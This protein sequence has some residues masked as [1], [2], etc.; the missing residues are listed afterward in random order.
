MSSSRWRKSPSHGKCSRKYCGSSLNYG[1]SHHQRQRETFDGHAFKSTT[2]GVR[3]NARE[4]GQISPRPP[5]GLPDAPVAVRTSRLSCGKAGKARIFTPVWDSSGESR[6][7]SLSEI[8]HGAVAIALLTLR[9][10]AVARG[11]RVFGVIV[12]GL[13]VI[14]DCAVEII[15][16]KLDQSS[17]S[18]ATSVRWRD[19]NHFSVVRFGTIEL[20]LRAINIAT[21]DERQQ[22]IR[23]KLDLGREVGSGA[24][25]ITLSEITIATVAQGSCILWIE[26]DC[27]GEVRNR[28]IKIVAS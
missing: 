17:I 21:V 7:K 10:P 18:P 26:F 5:F 27:G 19:P 8:R 13:V 16:Q 11:D 12:Q 24:V 4:N 9:N 23:G 25:E 6:L 20:L 28:T 15:F 14:G 1:H 3:P 22:V 2:G